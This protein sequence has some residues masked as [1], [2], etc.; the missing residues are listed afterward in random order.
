MI[1]Y[2]TNKRPHF[3]IFL[4]NNSLTPAVTKKTTNKN[5]IKLFI[6]LLTFALKKTLKTTVTAIP[7]KEI[8][9]IN[10]IIEYLSI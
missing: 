5:V 1:C 10:F 6:V 3:F 7:I 8:V 2:F 4:I 9:L